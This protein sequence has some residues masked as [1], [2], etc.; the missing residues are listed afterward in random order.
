MKSISKNLLLYFF[1]FYLFSILTIDSFLWV[2]NNSKTLSAIKDKAHKTV[3]LAEQIFP[4]N[5]LR[6]FSKKAF[7]EKSRQIFELTGLNIFLLNKDGEILSDSSATNN[8]LYEKD[9]QQAMKTGSGFASVIDKISGNK[10]YYYAEPIKFNG[11]V[12]G[13]I[14]VKILPEKFANK[15]AFV[16]QIIFPVSLLLFVI[17]LLF[18]FMIKKYLSQKLSELIVP[19]KNSLEK[20]KFES[21][22]VQDSIELNE[23]ATAF[24]HFA[25][26]MLNNYKSVKNE[27]D[28]FVELLSSLEDG[29]ATF[30][31]ENTL[32]FSS[33]QF[34][35]ILELK[36]I[37]ENIHIYDLIDFPPL[38]NDVRKFLETGNPI[39][40]KTK[41]YKHKFI[42][43]LITPLSSDY[44][45]KGFTIV[46]RDITDIHKLEKIRSD[47]VANVSHEF[48]TPLTAIRGFAETL[49]APNEMPLET[50]ERFLNKI[51]RQTIFLENMVNDLL[52]LSRIERNESIEITPL[53]IVPLIE[54]IVEE[55]R[56]KTT[57]ENLTFN[58]IPKFSG[59]IIVNAN[60]LL[61][62]NI[63]SNLISN[64]IQYS[65]ESGKIWLTVNANNERVKIEVADDGIGIPQ[66]EL[67]RIFERFYRTKNAKDR[68]ST[69]SGLGLSIFRNAIELL[70]GKYGVSSKLGEGSNFWCEIKLANSQN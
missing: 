13:F 65:K 5:Q 37:E 20:E 53:N 45:K 54:D 50:R 44:N 32:I 41:Y 28:N 51:R 14:R 70:H 2:E 47:F 36:Q 25:E 69:G 46:I 63:I 56:N 60:E 42:E 43:Y 52:Q 68:F 62:R 58:F 33:P 19:I 26:C 27:K 38:I 10:I 49:L 40:R 59:E 16:T 66:K 34:N 35:S 55:T 9:I 12:T 29:V 64:A 6:S 24:N 11:R 30:N 15:N 8:L 61:I 31:S 21:I 1:V 17:F 48:K 7:S 22:P 18:Y 23:I 67:N 4:K 39:K 57:S 3:V